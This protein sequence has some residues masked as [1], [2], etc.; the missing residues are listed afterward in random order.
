ML[1]ELM[2]RNYALIDSLS[3]NFCAGFN[4]L[5][6]E[7]GAGKSIL[8]GALGL[9]IGAKGD[10][11][12]IR[13][14]SEEALVSGTLIVKGNRE[15]LDWLES[16]G[17]ERDS[18]TVILRRNIKKNGRGSIYIQSIPVTRADLAEFTGFLFDIHGQHDHQSLLSSDNQRKLLDRYSKIEDEVRLFSSKFRE[19]SELRQEY[20]KLLENERDRNRQIEFLKYSI[21]EIDKASLY[22][23]EEEELEG[24]RKILAN[25]EK[26]YE[27]VNGAYNATAESKNGAMWYV[28]ESRAF[29]NQAVDIDS[30]LEEILRECDDIYYSL[31]D[32]AEELRGYR[33]GIN[34]DPERLNTVEERL[35]V[36]RTLKKKY[37]STIREVLE[38][39]ERAKKELLNL[40]NWEDRK[41]ELENNIKAL[42]VELKK[43]A[44]EISVKRKKNAELLALKIEEELKHL[45]MENAK[46]KIGVNEKTRAD[47]RYVL[48]MYGKDDVEFLISPN[49]GE[50]FKKLKSIASGGELSRVMLAIKT[51]LSETDHIDTMIFDE[52]DVGIGGEV[53]VA[54]G[55]RLKRLASVKQVLCITHLATIASYADN[56]IKVEKLEKDG[57]TVTRVKV[58]RDKERVKEIARMLAG[59]EDESTSLQHARQLLEKY[60]NL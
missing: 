30:S 42:E 35:S 40:E 46:F 52:I 29:L 11:S 24:E 21:G 58:I 8:I 39:R 10:T 18:D 3:V 15:A 44:E 4:V 45:G 1:E 34:F 2:V 6:G 50:N 38:Y 37:G 7:T 20:E 23:G 43:R 60:G 19:F 51:I 49:K 33:D 54:V 48:G 9:L 12:V 59:D 27:F 25:A 26:L 32:I 57:R 16:H 14:G 5:T 17:I 56:H 22:D 53:A 13:F 55:E 36:I 31:E 41:A 28:G 47:G